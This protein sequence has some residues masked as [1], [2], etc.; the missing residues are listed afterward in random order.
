SSCSDSS[1]R[2]VARRIPQPAWLDSEGPRFCHR[3]PV[4]ADQ[5]NRQWS[6]RC[7]SGHRGSSRSVLR[8][9]QRILDES[10]DCVGSLPCA[11]ERGWCSKKNSSVSN[12]SEAKEV[13][14]GGLTG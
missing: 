2:D 14:P 9:L 12:S 5:R 11:E 13:Q 3:R 7:Y 4:P 1:R 6:T 10:P 8:D